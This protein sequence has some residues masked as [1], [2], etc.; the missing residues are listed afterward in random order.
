MKIGIYSGTFDPVHNGH[1]AFANIAIEKFGLYKV[2]FLPEPRPRRKQG[3][4]AFEHRVN[5]INIAI[6]NN[7]KLG[8][9]K[10]NILMGDD[11]L[12]HFIEWP[13]VEELIDSLTFIIAL[14]KYDTKHV[15]GVIET[16]SNV[17]GKKINYK[18][19]DKATGGES[20]KSIKQ[21]IKRYQNFEGLDEKVADYIRANGLYS[22][23]EK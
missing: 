9:I 13:N 19:I 6:K 3:I 11:M 18:L 10:I 14:R 2:F 8:L 5:M 1:L 17:T 23:G 15:K 21:S 7:D 20:S 4:K 16:I 22:T 12:D